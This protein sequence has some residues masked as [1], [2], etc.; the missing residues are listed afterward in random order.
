M[1]HEPENLTLAHEETPASRTDKGV[2]SVPWLGGL[3][4]TPEK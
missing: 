2:G 4:L 3:S 1:K